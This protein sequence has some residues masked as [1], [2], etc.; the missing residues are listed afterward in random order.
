MLL[1]LVYAMLSGELNQTGVVGHKIFEESST[2]TAKP[3]SLSNFLAIIVHSHC[4]LHELGM[5]YT[6]ISEGHVNN[7][8]RQ[9]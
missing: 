1:Q 7:N 6:V 4:L 5:L 8:Y 2:A 9:N 3:N